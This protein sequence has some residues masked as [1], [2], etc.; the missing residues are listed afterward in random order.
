MGTVGQTMALNSNRE[1]PVDEIPTVSVVLTTFNRR[2]LLARAIASVRAQA[3]A[4]SELLVIDDGSTDGT[5]EDVIKLIHED[6]RIRYLHWA[7]Q[8]LAPA[9]N[10]G[11][12]LARG[13]F[14]TFLDSDDEYTRDHLGRRVAQFAMNPTLDFLHGGYQVIGPEGSDMVPDMRDPTKLIPLS[15]CV[16][17]GTFFGKAETFRSVGGFRPIFGTD[18]DLFQRIRARGFLIDEIRAPSY[19]YHRDTPDSMCDH[20]RVNPVSVEAAPPGENGE[21]ERSLA[22]NLEI[23]FEEFHDVPRLSH[24]GGGL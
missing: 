3:Y 15:E 8:G 13:A 23:S 17:G 7:N 2:A 21:E 24:G 22:E 10:W 4:D 12:Q 6:P 19:L 14:I 5:A 16:V 20:A 1:R 18:N 11:I 9:R